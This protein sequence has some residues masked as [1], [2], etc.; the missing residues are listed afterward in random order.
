MDKG[1]EFIN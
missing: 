1:E